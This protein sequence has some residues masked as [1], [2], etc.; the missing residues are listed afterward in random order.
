H[1]SWACKDLSPH[2]ARHTG[3]TLLLNAGA[4]LDAVGDI[5]GNKDKKTTMR[6]AKIHPRTKRSTIAMMPSINT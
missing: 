4:Q 3:A 5:L 2:W 1:F 6:Y